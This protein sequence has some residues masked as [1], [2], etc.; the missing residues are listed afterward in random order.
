[1][2]L[3]GVRGQIGRFEKLFAEELFP[4]VVNEVPVPYRHGHWLSR[5]IASLAWRALMVHVERNGERIAR[6]GW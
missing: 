5:L 4:L 6:A 1:M 2:A 3:S